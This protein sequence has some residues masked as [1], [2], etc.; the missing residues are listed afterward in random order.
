MRFEPAVGV[1]Y[2]PDPFFRTLGAGLAS[3]TQPVF[4]IEAGVAERNF[5]FY[6]HVIAEARG[7][8]EARTRTHERE[9]REFESLEH[10]KLG[11]AERALEEHRGRRIKYLEITRIKNNASRVAVAPFDA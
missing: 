2:N 4:H 6:E 10:L 7:F 8:Q 11:H 3:E 9:A 5:T 1:T